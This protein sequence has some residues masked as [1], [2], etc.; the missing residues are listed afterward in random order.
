M[1]R[2]LSI[3]TIGFLL[4]C[5]HSEPP[6]GYTRVRTDDEFPD[7]DCSSIIVEGNCITCHGHISTSSKTFIDEDHRICGQ[8]A[9]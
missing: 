7:Y 5:C 6:A 3:L 9:Y 4:S 8:F 2:I 1:R